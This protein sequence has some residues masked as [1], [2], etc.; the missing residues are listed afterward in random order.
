MFLH[1]CSTCLRPRPGLAPGSTRCPRFRPLGRAAWEC[2]PLAGPYVLLLHAL[3]LIYFTRRLVVPCSAGATFSASA[4]SAY[5]CMCSIL[6]CMQLYD[7]LASSAL[8]IHALSVS[9]RCRRGRLRIRPWFGHGAAGW[10]FSAPPETCS[11]LDNA[12]KWSKMSSPAVPLKILCGGLANTGSSRL[13][14]RALGPVV[15]M[16]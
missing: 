12:P 4:C 2:I 8:C 5:T 7:V 16:Q 14:A 11:G 9:H 3:L 1:K 6:V 13:G 10:G 15:S